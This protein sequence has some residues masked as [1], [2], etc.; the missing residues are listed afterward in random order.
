MGEETQQHVRFAHLL[1]QPRRIQRR[2]S[3]AYS[4]QAMKPK[5]I[6]YQCGL[7]SYSKTEQEKEIYVKC[8]EFMNHQYGNDR[9]LTM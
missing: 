5:H 4:G 9:G 6:S 3:A 1:S 7:T 2:P 8:I